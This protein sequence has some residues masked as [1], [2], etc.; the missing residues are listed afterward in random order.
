M[1][2]TV[3]LIMHAT[4]FSADRRKLLVKY[5]LQSTVE[6]DPSPLETGDISQG[7]PLAMEN[8][9]ASGDCIGN[10]VYENVPI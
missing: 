2:F 8:F 3:F 6:K 5:Q 1:T 7:N 9:R 10:I 4:I